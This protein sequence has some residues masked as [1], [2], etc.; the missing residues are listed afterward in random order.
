M[1]DPGIAL[2]IEVGVHINHGCPSHFFICQP[3]LE[4]RRAVTQR[5]LF[6]NVEDFQFDL[7][8]VSR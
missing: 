4:T 2:V 6:S 1:E 7:D 8:S 3:N 5:V